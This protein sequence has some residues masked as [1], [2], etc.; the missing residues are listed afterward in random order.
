ML[1]QASCMADW[2]CSREVDR[3]SMT[4]TGCIAEAEYLRLADDLDEAAFHIR[5]LPPQSSG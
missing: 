5:L 3:L 4:D 1:R 2:T